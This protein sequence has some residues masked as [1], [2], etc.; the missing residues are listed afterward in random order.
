VKWA[1]LDLNQRPHPCQAYPPDAFTLMSD[2]WPA[3][4]RGE[5]DRGCPLGTV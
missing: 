3:R 2:R 5:C 4:P 1:W